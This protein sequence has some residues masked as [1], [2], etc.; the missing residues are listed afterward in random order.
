MNIKNKTLDFQSSKK[1]NRACFGKSGDDDDDDDN[2]NNNNN[3]FILFITMDEQ[4]GTCL[5]H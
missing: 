4:N 3:A 5:K 2:Y 1:E